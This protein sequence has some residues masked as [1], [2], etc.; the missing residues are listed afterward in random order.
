MVAQFTIGCLKNSMKG[1]FYLQRRFAFIGHE[2]AKILQAEHGVTEF[3]GYVE[4]R[5][6]LVFLQ[7]QSEI[8]YQ[9]LLLDEEIVE[10]FVNTPLDLAYL[11]KLENTYGQ[12][13]LWAPLLEDRVIRYSL[14]LRA[15]PSD[16]SQYTHE[17]MLRMLQS[18]ARAIETMLDEQKPDFVFMSVISGLGSYLLYLI[19]KAKGIKTIMLYNP[20]LE[21]R[22]AITENPFSYDSLIAEIVT[23]SGRNDVDQEY[24]ARAEK[25]ITEFKNK[26][27]YYLEKSKAVGQYQKT[28]TVAA[29]FKFLKIANIGRSVTWLFKSFYDFYTSP[30]KT[31]YSTINP[32]FETWDKIIRKARVV[33]GYADLYDIP[34]PGEDY[35]FFPLQ[36]EPE[37]LPMLLAP[38]YATDQIWVI[39]QIARSLPVHFTLYVKEHPVMVGKRPRW[40]YQAIKKIPNVRLLDP[41]TSALQLV[42][43]TKLVFTIS[44]TT[45]MEAI[46]L[47]KPL[48]TLSDA[49][50]NVVTGV[51]RCHSVEDLPKMVQEKLA[52]FAYDQ[53]MIVNTVAALF[54]ESVAVDLT[55]LWDIEG[56]CAIEKKKNTLVPLAQLIM[57]KI[58]TVY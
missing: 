1:C 15:Y 17:E 46:L 44:S 16:Q 9:T 30:A 14:L 48:I 29:H 21:E 39:K 38:N 51:G 31:D 7:K 6:S 56:G 42:A 35:A 28:T 27:A 47:G 32:W 43:N 54:K 13:N 23:I 2:L 26:P 22:Y 5:S 36:S 10:N 34:K 11:Q 58:T 12:P 45:G 40:Y 52:G 50:Y 33:R 24:V 49:F 25:F 20:R 41:H 19:A 55:Q 4:Q 18:V 53:E 8:K 57:K 37:G 3:C